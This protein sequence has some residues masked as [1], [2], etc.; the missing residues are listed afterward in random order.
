MTEQTVAVEKYVRPTWDQYFI[1][2]ARSVGKRASCD[3]GR[4][5]CVI[6]RN[7]QILVA[8]YVGAPR[9]MPDCDEVGHQMQTIIHEDASQSQHCMR[10]AHAEQNAIVQAARV[11]VSIEGGTLYCK[12][13]P[14]P[15]CAK[16]IVNAGI[17]RVFCE[18]RYHNGG[19]AELMFKKLGI[20]LTFFDETTEQYA[21]Q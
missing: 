11:G 4:S 8:G 9:G 12:M 21:K 1:E 3:R 13:T 16:M 15:S 5:G 10:T 2:I 18:K 19:E 17:V 20:T 7:N 6:V 14:C